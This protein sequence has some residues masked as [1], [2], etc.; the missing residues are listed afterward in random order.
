MFTV[1]QAGT[2]AAVNVHQYLWGQM[3][4]SSITDHGPIRRQTQ[5]TAGT[6]GDPG[7]AM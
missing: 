7:Y 4:L 1:F 2:T 5:Y 6:T 3:G